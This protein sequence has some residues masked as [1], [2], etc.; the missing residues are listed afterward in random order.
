MIRDH[1][2]QNPYAPL[3]SERQHYWMALRMAKA[4]GTDLAAALATG[5]L[6]QDDWASIVTR[7]RGCPWTEGCARWLQ[8]PIDSIRDL[9]EGCRNA[10]LFEDLR[11][12][13][14]TQCAAHRSV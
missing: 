4:T 6:T 8:R 5:R 14:P 7:C 10:E 12:A 9:P 2:Y 3:G 11:D 1:A 13:P